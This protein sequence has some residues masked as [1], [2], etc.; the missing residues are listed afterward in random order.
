MIARSGHQALAAAGVAPGEVVPMALFCALGHVLCS[1][2]GRF[3]GLGDV[4]LARE[5]R[6]RR[7]VMSAPVFEGVL[8]TVAASDLIALFPRD[9]AERRAQSSGITVYAPPVT[10]PPPLLCM[11]WRRKHSGDPAHIWLRG[12]VREILAPLGGAAGGPAPT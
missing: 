12:I 11:I 9:L 8:Q 3:H 10:I 6:S 4:A 1:P 5:G 7:V 2:D